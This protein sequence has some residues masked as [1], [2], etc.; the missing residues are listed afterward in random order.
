MRSMASPIAA[1]KHKG[2]I[3]GLKPVSIGFAPVPRW[4]RPRVCGGASARN[5]VL[6]QR[7]EHAAEPG[8]G[9]LRQLWV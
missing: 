6:E 8:P 9:G 1:L 3:V 2:K 7:D 5:A 4:R